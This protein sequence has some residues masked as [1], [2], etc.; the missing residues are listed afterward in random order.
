MTR[1]NWNYVIN[2][3]I[4]IHR[5]N[6]ISWR[7][8]HQCKQII[9][10]LKRYQEIL[11]NFN[12]VQHINLPTRK[13]S[14]IIDHIITYIPNKILYSSVLPCPS[15][16]DHDEPYIIVKIPINKYQPSYKFIRDIKTFDLQKYIDAFKQLPF[17]IVYSFDKP[18]D[19]L[20][21]LNKTF[22]NVSNV[23]YL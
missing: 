22:L 14:K 21:I 12:F 23:T 18:D 5:N 11:E 15:I 16:S 2:N 17:S 3:W 13:R 6:Y 19:Q 10:A 4:D 20:G 1:P 8:K 7:Y 9:K